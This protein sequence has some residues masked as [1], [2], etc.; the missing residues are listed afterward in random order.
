MFVYKRHNSEAAKVINTKIRPGTGEPGMIKY[1]DCLHARFKKK[2]IKESEISPFS[3]SV[4]R[5][6]QEHSVFS[7]SSDS[8]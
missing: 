4:D 5:D 7:I 8:W 6:Y 2:E 3:H 1:V